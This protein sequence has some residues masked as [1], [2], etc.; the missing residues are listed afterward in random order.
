MVAGRRV[1]SL[2]RPVAEV[3]E[4]G[5]KPKFGWQQKAS[6]QM[7]KKLVSD[8]F[9]PRFDNAQRALMK[10]TTRATRFSCTH[11]SAD[12]R[13]EE[14]PSVFPSPPVP[15][16]A[17][18]TPLFH[19]T[20]R[21]GR[22]LDQFGHHRAACFEAGVLGKK[23][24]PHECAAAQVC[25]EGARVTTSMFVRDMDLAVPN[26]IGSGGLEVEANGLTLLR[27]AQV[28]IDTTIVFFLRRDGTARPRSANIGG[29]ALKTLHERKMLPTLN[30]SMVV[31]KRASWSWKLN[32]EV[33]RG[34]GAI[35]VRF[36]DS[37]GPKGSFGLARLGRN[38][39]GDVGAQ[40]WRALLP[41][42]LKCRS[43]T[44]GTDAKVPLIHD[45]MRE[46]RFL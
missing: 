21:C 33:E 7:E 25:K 34:D 13:H 26:A 4:L 14:E 18:V 28:A 2:P 23:G 5:H 30:C 31:G 22:I 10:S 44:K 24:F 20:C 39:K 37:L 16:V 43:Q 11:S 40:S 27:R 35:P 8:L 45:V 1:L 29:A 9:W 15:Q 36:G 3:A 12:I 41:G 6:R 46:A 19:R 17:L 32:R 38:S 42:P